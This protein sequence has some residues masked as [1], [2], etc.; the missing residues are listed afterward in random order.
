[1]IK[2]RDIDTV[3]PPDET[4]VALAPGEVQ[5]ELLAMLQRNA[6]PREHLL[7]VK[8]E[9]GRVFVVAQQGSATHQVFHLAD[10]RLWVN[11]CRSRPNCV[12]APAVVS[13]RLTL[14]ETMKRC[15]DR[16]PATIRTG[17]A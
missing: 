13:T 12:V 17:S 11:Y 4:A 14:S 6:G 8:T 2:K 7:R 1:M 15:R 10:W 5:A 16:Q 9:A 3:P